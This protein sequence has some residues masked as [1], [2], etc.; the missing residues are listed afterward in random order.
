MVWRMWQMIELFFPF[1]EPLSGFVCLCVCVCVYIF[2]PI[3]LF[4]FSSLKNINIKK[5]NTAKTPQEPTTSS[6][7]YPPSPSLLSQ[8][9]PPPSLPSLPPSSSPSERPS[10]STLFLLFL[11]FALSFGCFPPLLLVLFLLFLFLL[12]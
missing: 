5:K 12:L 2:F 11:S 10:E 8:S 6:N 9:S 7:S 4:F 1:L 3:F